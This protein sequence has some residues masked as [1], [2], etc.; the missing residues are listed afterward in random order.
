ML[1][2]PCTPAGPAP[3]SRPSRGVPLPSR[4]CRESFHQG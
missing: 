4:T 3:R 1:S 2:I